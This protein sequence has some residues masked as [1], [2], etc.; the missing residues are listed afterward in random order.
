MVSMQKIVLKMLIGLLMLTPIFVSTTPM[1]AQDFVRCEE[2]MS[3]SL[4]TLKNIAKYAGSLTSNQCLNRE[5]L[6]DSTPRFVGHMLSDLHSDSMWQPSNTGNGLTVASSTESGDGL[7]LLVYR[8]EMVQFLVGVM[9]ESR[10]GF[11]MQNFQADED[12]LKTYGG[13]AAVV[14]KA[15]FLAGL[16]PSLVQNLLSTDFPLPTDEDV[17]LTFSL[18]N[19]NIRGID[20][21]SVL[22]ETLYLNTEDGAR[23]IEM[24]NIDQVMVNISNGPIDGSAQFDPTDWS[25]QRGEIGLNLDLGLNSIKSTTVFS[26]GHGVERQILQMTAQ[27]GNV[28]LLGEASFAESQQQFKLQANVANLLTLSTL[29]SLTPQGLSTPSLGFLFS[30]PIEKRD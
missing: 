29:T 13:F 19:N 23:I 17:T 16:L 3:G 14:I 7:E 4:S 24:L 15:D 21:D 12:W 10:D 11:I 26:K 2:T 9:L 8:M 22:E 20:L 6:L 5:G 30:I 1:L 25:L 27:I 28:N 18:R